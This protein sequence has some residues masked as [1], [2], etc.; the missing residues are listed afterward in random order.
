M[1]IATVIKVCLQVVFLLYSE[2]GCASFF[3]DC[4]RPLLSLVLLSLIITLTNTVVIVNVSWHEILLIWEE[5]IS[6]PPQYP[7]V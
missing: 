1:K 5:L 7:F 4:V 2:A 6:T 3:P